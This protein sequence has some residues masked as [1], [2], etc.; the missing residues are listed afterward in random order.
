M[1]NNS[2]YQF[3]IDI[4]PNGIFIANIYCAMK[5]K[6]ILTT[7]FVLCITCSLLI[8]FNNIS[9]AQSNNNGDSDEPIYD[10]SISQYRDVDLT[11]EELEL[12]QILT[13]LSK[14]GIRMGVEIEFSLFKGMS[15]T[16]E[17]FD[18]ESDIIIKTIQQKITEILSSKYTSAEIVDFFK[19]KAKSEQMSTIHSREDVNK[20]LIAIQQNIKILNLHPDIKKALCILIGKDLPRIFSKTILNRGKIPEYLKYFLYKKDCDMMEWITN[21]KYT[22]ELWNIYL[23]TKQLALTAHYDI[24][25][26]LISN[27][28]ED[29]IKAYHSMNDNYHLHISYDDKQIT[30]LNERLRL[31]N[32]LVM[33]ERLQIGNMVDVTYYNGLY[34]FDESLYT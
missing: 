22:H 1:L 15:G 4:L 16:V 2:F 27:N 8:E 12:K 23:A 25:K 30:N 33:L 9:F 32:I 14:K 29:R 10:N 21:E 31:L 28:M 34:I 24:Y 3:T 20:I 11:S 26:M 19:K 7:L 13:D 18:F 17:L 6:N 5:N